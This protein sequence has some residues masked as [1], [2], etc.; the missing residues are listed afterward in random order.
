MPVSMRGPL[1]NLRQPWLFAYY[2][3][4]FGG[5]SYLFSHTSVGWAILGGL[6]FAGVMSWMRRA[7]G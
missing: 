2:A 1:S 6:L 7:I 4:G 3:V 5:L